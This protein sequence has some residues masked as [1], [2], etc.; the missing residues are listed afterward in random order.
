MKKC[1]RYY[2]YV[3]GLVPDDINMEL[4]D[5]DSCFPDENSTYRDIVALLDNQ[6]YDIR[7]SVVKKLVKYAAD[8][9]KNL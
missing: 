1:Y 7:K 3:E 4:V 9:V 5:V 6:Q 8:Q 2:Y